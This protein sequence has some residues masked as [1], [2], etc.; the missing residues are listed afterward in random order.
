M[1]P[2]EVFLI[3]LLKNI[4]D[5]QVNRPSELL[6]REAAQH[7]SA[8]LNLDFCKWGHFNHYPNDSSWGQRDM[9]EYWPWQSVIVATFLSIENHI[10]FALQSRLRWSCLCFNAFC[11]TVIWL[12]AHMSDNSSCCTIQ[13]PHERITAV[14]LIILHRNK[15]AQQPFYYWATPR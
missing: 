7:I 15:P 11:S 13:L 6:G 4:S 5:Y 14:T 10:S 9:Q 12:T 3:I 2:P 1:K 8:D